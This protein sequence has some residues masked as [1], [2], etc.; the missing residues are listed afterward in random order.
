[1]IRRELIRGLGLVATASLVVGSIIGTGVFLKAAPMA[2]AARAP[3]PL[4]LA[5]VAAGLLSLAG[6]LS[7]AELGAMLPAAGGE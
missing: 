3:L 5:W 7:Y 4:L 2:Q 6:A 1:M